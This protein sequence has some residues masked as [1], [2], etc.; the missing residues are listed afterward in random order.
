[1]SQVSGSETEEV[2]EPELHFGPFRLEAATRLWR[3]DQLVEIR[4]RPLMMLRYLA[5]R[6]NRLGLNAHNIVP[7][8]L[9]TV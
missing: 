4:P 3:G 5:E 1:V 9:S 2:G 7:G 6:P 8:F